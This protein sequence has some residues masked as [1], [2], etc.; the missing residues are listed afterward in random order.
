MKQ[1]TNKLMQIGIAL[2]AGV[3]ILAACNNGGSSSSVDNFAYVT[4]NNNEIYLYNIN[5]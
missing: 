1:Q 3:I 4:T 5:F 2:T